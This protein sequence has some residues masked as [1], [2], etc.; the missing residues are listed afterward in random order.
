M[1]LKFIKSLLFV[2]SWFKSSFL[3][4]PAYVS[5]GPFESECKR[6][7]GAKPFST[8]EAE[9]RGDLCQDGTA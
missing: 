3:G 7:D 5:A 9:V 2:V 6:E 1:N 4:G 8:G